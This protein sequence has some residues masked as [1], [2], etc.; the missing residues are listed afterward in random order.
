MPPVITG[1]MQMSLE[2]IATPRPATSLPS[3][4]KLAK[5][6]KKSNQSE[7]AAPPLL[8]SV[9]DARKR[10]NIG[11]SLIWRLIADGRL[12][13]VRLGRRTLVPVAALHELIAKGV[14]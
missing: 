14:A 10:L 8:I 12:R 13:T 4:A 11:N 9:L 6:E 7:P 3:A 2:E 1:G 5:R